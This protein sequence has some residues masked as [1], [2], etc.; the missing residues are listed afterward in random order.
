MNR[1]VYYFCLTISDKLYIELR[2]KLIHLGT[3]VSGFAHAV[4][5]GRF[6]EEKEQADL[7]CN[8]KSVKA[9]ADA[10]HL[11]KSVFLTIFHTRNI[12]SDIST[13]ADFMNIEYSIHLSDACFFRPLEI[14]GGL[15]P[16]ICDLLRFS[17]KLHNISSSLLLNNLCS[18]KK[19]K[20]LSSSHCAF[21]ILFNLFVHN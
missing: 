16:H 17:Y 10:H 8:I 12:S 19:G 20:S 15:L 18:C 7:F 3:V 13:C 4:R 9:S 6:S 2:N 5:H 14:L 21:R 11:V 1:I